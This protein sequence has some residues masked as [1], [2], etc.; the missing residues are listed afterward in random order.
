MIKTI[1]KHALKCGYCGPYD[2]WVKVTPSERGM[3]LVDAQLCPKCRS[4]PV[5]KNAAGEDVNFTPMSQADFKIPKRFYDSTI[6]NFLAKSPG[7]KKVKQIAM[8]YVANFQKYMEKGTGGLIF[9]GSVGTGK[10]HL[11]IGIM[12]AVNTQNMDRLCRYVNVFDM[13]ADIKA[14]WS[15]SFTSEAKVI[16]EYTK[17]DLIVVDEIGVQYGSTAENVILFRILNQRYLEMKPTI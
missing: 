5:F 8:Q 17:Y 13:V 6:E 4:S 12:K 2:G 10:T 3:R 11:A 16:E 7:Q 14:S 9:T 1:E 15:D